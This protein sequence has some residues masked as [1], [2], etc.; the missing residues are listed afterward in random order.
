VRFYKNK[1][2]PLIYF[3]GSERMVLPDRR[4]CRPV[5]CGGGRDLLAVFYAIIDQIN[6]TRMALPRPDD[7]LMENSVRLYHFA[8]RLNDFLLL[9]GT[10]LNLHCFKR[11]ALPPFIFMNVYVIAAEYGFVNHF[12]SP[13]FHSNTRVFYIFI[14]MKKADIV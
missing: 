11:H 14:K 1:K 2:E 7:G 4:T 8:N 9:L 13:Q 12:S 5:L 3:G 6:N 10:Y